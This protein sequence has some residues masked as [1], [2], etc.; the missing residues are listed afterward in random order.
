MYLV[1]M[2]ASWAARENGAIRLQGTFRERGAAFDAA[3]A[4]GYPI[5]DVLNIGEPGQCPARPEGSGHSF[6]TVDGSWPGECRDCRAPESMLYVI[7]TYIPREPDD[8]L[9][10]GPQYA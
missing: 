9:V 10:D 4:H 6:G 3:D 7:G 8:R 1:T 2:Y 5:V